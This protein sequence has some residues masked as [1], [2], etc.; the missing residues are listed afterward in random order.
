MLPARFFA[1]VK[2]PKKKFFSPHSS[3]GLSREAG[4]GCGD[5]A[6]LEKHPHAYPEP[7]LTFGTLRMFFKRHEVDAMRN[8]FAADRRRNMRVIPCC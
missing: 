8:G 6:G 1:V 7:V 2:V 5:E 4:K 3:Q